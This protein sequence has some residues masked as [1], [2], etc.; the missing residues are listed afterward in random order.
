MDQ[1]STNYF[2]RRIGVLED[3]LNELFSPLLNEF[4]DIYIDYCNESFVNLICELLKQEITKD[5]PLGDDCPFSNV[6]LY[7]SFGEQIK[8]HYQPRIMEYYHN[9]KTVCPE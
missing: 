8:S 9:R 1:K 4:M 5:I 2:T 7:N 6:I 3:K